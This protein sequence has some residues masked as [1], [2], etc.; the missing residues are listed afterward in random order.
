MQETGEC[1]KIP[2]SPDSNT[3]SLACTVKV[4]G[5]I[6]N[7]RL[8]S[9]IIGIILSYNLLPHEIQPPSLDVIHTLYLITK[10]DFCSPSAKGPV[11]FGSLNA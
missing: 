1:I 9:K 4:K 10:P 7:P 2:A 3:A 11:S 5:I 6:E 8:F